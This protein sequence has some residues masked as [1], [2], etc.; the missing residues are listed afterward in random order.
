MLATLFVQMQNLLPTFFL[1][2]ISAGS[3]YI[4]A[5]C[6][7]REKN[8]VNDMKIICVSPSVTYGYSPILQ[9]AAKV[10]KEQQNNYLCAKK[11]QF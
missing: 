6:Y 1:Y 8:E 11:N 5:M 2:Q 4:N 10:N 9:H 7:C 3:H